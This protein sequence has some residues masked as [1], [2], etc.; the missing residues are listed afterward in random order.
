MLPSIRT[1]IGRV[2]WTSRGRF[3]DPLGNDV[4]AHDAA[5]DVDEDPLD[6]RILQNDLEGLRHFFP[7]GPAP[8]VQE[9]GRLAAELLQD[10]EGCHGQSGAVHHAA[11]VPVQLDVGE[12]VF[13]G[14]DFQGIELG[15]VEHVGVFAVAEHGVVVEGDLRIHRH[16]PAGLGDH[17]RVDLREKAVLFQAEAVQVEEQFHAVLADAPLEP[18]GEGDLARL[19]GAQPG[20][21]VDGEDVDLFRRLLRHFFDLHPPFGRSDEAVTGGFPVKGD[22]QVKLPGDLHRLFHQY[23]PHPEPFGTGLRRHQLP[24]EQFFAQFLRLLGVVDELDASP[25]AASAGIDLRLHHAAPPHLL[26]GPLHLVGGERDP[27]ARDRY[28]VGTQNFLCLIFVDV[29]GVRS[30]GLKIVPCDFNDSPC[31]SKKTITG[32]SCHTRKFYQR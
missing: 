26:G 24:A 10:V 15:V 1:T 32:I 4:A 29:H 31:G 22:G 17:Q 19:V 21:G 2:Q 30:I 13:A 6:V 14:V 28:A 27:S 3:D 16:Q 20:E 12:V 11:D 5:E 9:I 7:G 23:P 18:Q 8:H 25:L